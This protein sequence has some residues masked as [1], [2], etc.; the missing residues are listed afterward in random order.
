MAIAFDIT[1]IISTVGSDGV[2]VQKLVFDMTATEIDDVT[3]DRLG[4]AVIDAAVENPPAGDARDVVV[5][6]A[7][8]NN[9]KQQL[10][11]RLTARKA[12]AAK[13]AATTDLST[14]T[15][16]VSDVEVPVKIFK[17][18]SRKTH[19][20][21]ACIA[22]AANKRFPTA[23]EVVRAHKGCNCKIKSQTVTAAE[24]ET[25][26]PIGVRVHDLRP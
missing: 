14:I 12:L 8:D 2:T 6:Y 7:N 5:Q 22:H 4:Q 18:S 1:K 17:L 16:A 21:K 20:C 15:T 10:L 9:W 25:F 3:G 26:F 19:A 13:A 23:G 24:Y 11:D